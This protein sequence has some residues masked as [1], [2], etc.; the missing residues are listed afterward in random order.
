MTTGQSRVM[1]LLLVLLALEMI[2]H[3]GVKDWL[4][5]W[6]G[7]LGNILPGSVPKG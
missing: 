7:S 2:I 1:V 3:P 5:T 4:R 6:V